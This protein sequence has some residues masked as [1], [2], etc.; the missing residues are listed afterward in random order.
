MSNSIEP[1]AAQPST[2]QTSDSRTNDLQL[3]TVQPVIPADL[4][5]D[6]TILLAQ[7]I[8]LGLH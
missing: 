5:Y 1:V 2:A 7:D 4:T 3:R 6:L 8:H